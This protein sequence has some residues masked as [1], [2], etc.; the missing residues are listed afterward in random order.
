VDYTIIGN[1]VNLAAR[2]QPHADLGGVLLAHE[3]YSLVKDAMLGEETGTITV[4][5]FPRPVKTYRVVSLYDDTSIQGRIIRKEQEGLTLIIDRKKLTGK[6]QADAIRALQEA[7]GQ[8]K[9]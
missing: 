6:G 4:K 5:G 1:E 3:T 7:V 9:D 8:L 2:L